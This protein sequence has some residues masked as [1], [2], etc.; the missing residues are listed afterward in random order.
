MQL[1]RRVR[2]LSIALLATVVGGCE[3]PVSPAERVE[4]ISLNAPQL[5]VAVGGTLQLSAL[6]RDINGAVVTGA[7]IAYTSD[8]VQLATVNTAGV[9]S[10]VAVG[11]VRITA[12]VGSATATIL[13]T[14][15]PPPCPINSTLPLLTFPQTVTGTLDG[16]DCILSTISNAEGYRF[17]LTSAGTVHLRVVSPSASTAAVVTN[18]AGELLA[19]IASDGG[20]DT[21]SVLVQLSAGTYFAWALVQPGFSGS[22]TMIAQLAQLCTTA[23]SSGSVALGASVAGTI[24]PTACLGA[25]T[26]RP[27]WIRSFTVSAL[28]TLAVSVKGTG[29]TPQGVV[30]DA[31]FDQYAE[32]NAVTADSAVVV[33]FYAPGT[34]YVLVSNAAGGG[35]DLTLALSDGEIIACSAP[36][37]TIALPGNATG[38]LSNDDCRVQSHYFADLY[39]L[40]VPTTQIV[41]INLASDDFD[42]YLTLKTI[43]GALVT[44]NDDANE[45]TLNS[46]IRTT[47]QAG[48]YIIEASSFG[49]GETGDYTLTVAP[50]AGSQSPLRLS[51]PTGRSGI[52]FPRSKS[53]RSARPESR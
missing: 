43:G 3:T 31:D 36:T 20:G 5:T 50:V 44:Q 17:T 16:T 47:V 39:F 35:G 22:Y 46:R 37:D 26:G 12:T 6:P 14:V 27:A 48:Q 28:D 49:P 34:Y 30:L 13:L 2:A 29:F 19:G 42:S 32:L 45:T 15:V 4:S 7:T 21:A 38:A 41:E 9:V 23:S 33:D 25:M 10:G 8:S 52:V 53:A 18:G 1:S 51:P 11:E 24:S 40:N